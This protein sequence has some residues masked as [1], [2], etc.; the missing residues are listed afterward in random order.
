VFIGVEAGL[1]NPVHDVDVVQTFVADY[2]GL[3]HVDSTLE[4]C[5]G[6]P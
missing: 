5:K 2:K 4:S 1:K 6:L 3:I